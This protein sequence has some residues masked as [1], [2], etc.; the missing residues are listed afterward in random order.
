MGLVC[1]WTWPRES[2]PREDDEEGTYI[3]IRC[4][5]LNKSGCCCWIGFYDIPADGRMGWWPGE[6]SWCF[7]NQN[8]VKPTDNREQ[9]NKSLDIHQTEAGGEY[10]E[11][12]ENVSFQIVLPYYLRWSSN[13]LKTQSPHC[14]WTLAFHLK[15]IYYFRDVD[16]W[17]Q[18]FVG[19]YVDMCI[20]IQPQLIDTTTKLYISAILAPLW[21]GTTLFARILQ[22]S[23]QKFGWPPEPENL[24]GN[25]KG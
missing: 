18:A 11:E 16:G 1:S 17:H 23:L 5:Y 6:T 25:P 3:F 10:Q 13:G 19:T 9:M 20:P 14:L 8:Q 12:R 2:Q 15:G 4:M 7:L 22:W 21:I 24:E